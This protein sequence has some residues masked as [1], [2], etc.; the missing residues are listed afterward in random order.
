[1]KRILI[2][3]DE[4]HFRRAM[5][6]TLYKEGYLAFAVEDG[7]R[8]L[9][10]LK[11]YKPHLLILDLK[12]PKINGIDVLKKIRIEQYSLPIIIVT[13]YKELTKDPEVQMANISAFMVKPIDLNVLKDKVNQLLE[14]VE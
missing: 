10:N 13:A 14:D 6:E 5:L 8:A 4:G 3:E 2:A 1:M 7:S 12:M 11:A 9:E